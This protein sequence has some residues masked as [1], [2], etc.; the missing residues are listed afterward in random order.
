MARIAA[1]KFAL[2]SVLLAVV[3]AGSQAQARARADTP[4]P[5][6]SPA[7]VNVSELPRQGQEIYGL[8]RQGGPFPSGKDG[9]VFGNRERLLPPNRRGYYR[10]YTVPTP[11][12]HDR[13]ARRIVCGG[14]P[15][16]PDACFYTAD[17]YASFR[18]IVEQAR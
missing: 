12:A 9:V 13:G 6:G 10:E 15:R 11:G 2:T 3:V 18:L 8:I 1:V 4:A 5:L 17:H 16:S 7:V 14:P